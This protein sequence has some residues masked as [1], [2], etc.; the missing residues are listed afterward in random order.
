MHVGEI[1][2]FSADQAASRQQRIKQTSPPPRDDPR[3][4]SLHTPAIGLHLETHRKDSPKKV[5]EK[6]RTSKC[7][8][9]QQGSA[10]IS[11]STALGD[12]NGHE[13]SNFPTGSTQGEFLAGVF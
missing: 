5:Q 2:P 11:D 6:P 12:K 8:Q 13:G 10:S 4:K 9:K 7:G 3:A 1:P